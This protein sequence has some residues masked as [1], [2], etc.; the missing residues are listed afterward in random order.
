MSSAVPAGVEGHWT[1]VHASRAVL[2]SEA[3]GPH[4]DLFFVRESH[5]LALL[6]GDFPAADNVLGRE[7]DRDVGESV[8]D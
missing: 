4:S 8:G 2:N 5:G 1:R 3:S 7:A 6:D